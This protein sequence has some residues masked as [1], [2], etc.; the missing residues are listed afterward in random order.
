M[1]SAQPKILE[2]V[3]EVLEVDPDGKK[4]DK[5]A[6]PRPAAAAAVASAAAC[7]RSPLQ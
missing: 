3:F 7:L 1:G 6:P 2:D 4:F 5:G